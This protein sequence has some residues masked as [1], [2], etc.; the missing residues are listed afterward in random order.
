VKARYMLEPAFTAL[1]VIVIAISTSLFAVG[2]VATF[3]GLPS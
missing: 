2:I 3:V 1:E